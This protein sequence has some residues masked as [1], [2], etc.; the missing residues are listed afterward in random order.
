MQSDKPWQ[1]LAACKELVVMTFILVRG[2]HVLAMYE[3]H[4][5]K[6]VQFE[7]MSRKFCFFHRCRLH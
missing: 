1:T 7:S 2:T 3:V 6:V 5:D 4:K